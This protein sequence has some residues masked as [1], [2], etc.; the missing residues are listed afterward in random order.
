MDASVLS[1]NVGELQQVDWSQD[2]RRTAID[3]QPMS[4]PVRVYAD[5]LGED[6]HGYAGHGGVDQ[7]VYAYSREDAEF[8]EAELGRELR[9]GVFGENLTTAGLAVSGAVTGERW[10]VGSTLLEVTTPRIPCMTFT[11]FWGV[12]GLIK[13]FTAAGRPGAYLR[14]VETGEIAAGDRIEVLSRPD[15]GVTVADLLAARA[16]DRSKIG[17]IRAVELPEKWKSWQESLNRVPA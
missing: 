8:W 11:G 6:A 5:R 1:V 13:R 4:G 7:A 17:R 12:Q 9:A 2:Q 10:R 14:V 16:G 15:H 3:K